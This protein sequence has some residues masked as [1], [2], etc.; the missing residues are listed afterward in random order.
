MGRVVVLGSINRDLVLRVEAHPRPGETVAAG[1]LEEYPGGK[2]ANQAVAARRAGAA[3]LLAGAVGDD[4]HGRAMLE[5]LNMERIGLDHVKVIEGRPTG[6]A[7]IAVDSRAENAIL[8]SAGANAA[9]QPADAAAIQFQ[10]GDIA[11][12]QFEVPEPFLRA[13]FAAARAAGG[14]TLLNPAPMRAIAPDLLALVD[15]LVLNETEL[16]SATGLPAEVLSDEAAIAAASTGLAASSRIVVVTLGARGVLAIHSQSAVRLPGRPAAAVDTTGAGDCF[17]GVL[18]ASLAAGQD[19][20]AALD[21]ANRA[22]AISVTRRGAAS[23][24]PLQHE[25]D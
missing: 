7:V 8:V 9:P 25:L 6:I 17:T 22:A 20:A 21:R 24:M 12:G 3:V 13:G 15:I 4:G 23:S 5:F 2:G 11:V 19:L 10:A 16:Q 18:A 14:R 1:D